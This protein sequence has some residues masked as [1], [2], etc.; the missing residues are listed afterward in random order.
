ML[1]EQTAFFHTKP[2]TKEGVQ[3]PLEL[4]Q[5]HQQN[6]QSKAMT[7]AFLQSCHD[8]SQS[9]FPLSQS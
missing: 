9:I 1:V 8:H 6:G 7:I 3:K 2:P 5:V 4:M